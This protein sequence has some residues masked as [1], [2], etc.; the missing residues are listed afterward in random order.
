MKVATFLIKILV[1]VWPFPHSI[2][3]SLTLDFNADNWI[4]VKELNNFKAWAWCLTHFGTGE[5][6]G[7]GVGW[8][9]GVHP[10]GWHSVATAS[11]RSARSSSTARSAS[12]APGRSTTT[13][14]C[15]WPDVGSTRL[16]DRQDPSSFL[17]QFGS[18]LCSV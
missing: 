7:G 2:F 8:F 5:L 13:S 1:A 18:G 4:Q 15:S 3:R 10:P 11:A 9:D 12:T 14:R 6:L 16:F 17:G